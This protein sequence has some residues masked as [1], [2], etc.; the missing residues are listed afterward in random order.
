MRKIISFLILALIILGNLSLTAQ[1]EQGKKNTDKVTIKLQEPLP[2][3]GNGETA[4]EITM[5]DDEDATQFI[6]KYIGPI[7]KFAV[8]LIGGLA[9]LM[10]VIGGLQVTL[11]GASQDGASQ[12]KERI[13]KALSGLTLLLIS[14][15]ILHTI[16]PNFFSW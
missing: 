13:I 4:G 5:E 10:I 8:I 3:M 14:G 11:S 1:A 2:G 12:G 9:V 6:Q 7:Y 16:N 15:L